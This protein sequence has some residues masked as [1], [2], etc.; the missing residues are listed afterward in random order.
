MRA[1]VCS[2]EAMVTVDAA[3]GDALATG[4]VV[5]TAARLQSVAP[6]D[7]VVVDEE[8]YRLTRHAFGFHELPDV[9]AKGKRDPCRA[10]LVGERARVAGRPPDVA[11]TAR[12]PGPGVAADRDPL[13]SRVSA[14]RR[15]W[16]RCW[17]RRGSASPG[18]G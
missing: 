4:D 6:P 3:P 13:G 11:D 7:R 15:T 5:N 18:W 17:V 12:R 10:W 14:G 16:S 9:D 1:A 2:G 8:T